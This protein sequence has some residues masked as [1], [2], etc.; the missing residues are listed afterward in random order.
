MIY[1]LN[2]FSFKTKAMKP[3]VVQRGHFEELQEFAQ[4][5][6]NGSGYP[7]SLWQLIQATKTSFEVEKQISSSE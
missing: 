7:K 6:K 1:K 2:A 4:S 5:I 3:E